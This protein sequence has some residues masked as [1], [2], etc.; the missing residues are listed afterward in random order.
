MPTQVLK[1]R[2]DQTHFADFM[3][4]QSI[5]LKAANGLLY[6]KEKNIVGEIY[7]NYFGAISN[8]LK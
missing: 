8:K 2:F 5:I 1:K 7:E 6:Q 4:I 3:Q